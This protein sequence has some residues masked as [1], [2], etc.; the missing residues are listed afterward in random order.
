MPINDRLYVR[1]ARTSTLGASVSALFHSAQVGVFDS[2][3]TL[4]LVREAA[5]SSCTN[6]LGYCVSASST[7]WRQ[8][9]TSGDMCNNVPIPASVTSV[10][11]LEQCYLGATPDE[12]VGAPAFAPALYTAE[13][14]A[15]AS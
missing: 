7:E 1:I 5:A 4:L 6:S 15:A 2:L 8:C 13:A 14:R 11:Q 12:C 10:A 3:G 9:C